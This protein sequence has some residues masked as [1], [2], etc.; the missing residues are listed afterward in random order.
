MVQKKRTNRTVKPSRPEVRGISSRTFDLLSFLIPTLACV[1]GYFSILGIGFLGDDFGA[2]YWL[3][4]GEMAYLSKSH[5]YFRPL[6][7][8]SFALDQKL[9]GLNAY[10]YHVINLLL[11]IIATLGV[12]EL[13]RMMIRRRYA[14][15]LAGV[16]FA[17]YPVHPE[18]VAWVSGRFDL[19]CGATLVWSFVLYL[20]SKVTASGKVNPAGVASVILLALACLSKEQAFVFPLTLILY[21]IFFPPDKKAESRSLRVRLLRTIPWWAIVVVLFFVR[22]SYIGG[23]GGYVPEGN[24]HIT[25]L[26]ILGNLTIRPLTFLFLP[27]NRSIMNAAGLQSA[28]ILGL[29]LLLPLCVIYKAS[30]RLTGFVIVAIVLNMIPTI[31][32]GLAGGDLQNSRFLYTPSIFSSILLASILTSEMPGRLKSFMQI[33]LVIY[34]AAMLFTLST[35]LGPWIDAGKEVAKASEST[36]ALVDQYRDKWG[37]EYKKI[38]AFDVR[39]DIVGAWVF[40]VGFPEMLK[41][42]N[43][44]LLDEVEVEVINEGIQEYEDIHRMEFGLENDTV[45]W[46]Y[47]TKDS[48][49]V[50]YETE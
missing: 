10:P 20:K 6:V 22:W 30:P 37:T 41:L 36:D 35:N 43:P 24:E 1:I 48:N 13:C 38:V 39:R 16:I 18:A 28:I 45:A 33:G 15:M 5:V 46:L 44:G 14:G 23:F 29:C 11:H 2:L 3:N 7:F 19:A 27:V 34:L 42:R 31:H 40:Q 17:L 32:L 26:S 47:V 8:L 12:V 9:Y 49:F 50:E 25:I 4:R 21:E